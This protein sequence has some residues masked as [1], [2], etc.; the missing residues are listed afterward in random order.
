MLLLN[1]L[2]DYCESHFSRDYIYYNIFFMISSFFFFSTLPYDLFAS[3]PGI[4]LYNV[5]QCSFSVIVQCTSFHFLFAITFQYRP[6]TLKLSFKPG[7][8]IT[9]EILNTLRSNVI[10]WIHRPF[11]GVSCFVLLFLNCFLFWDF[12]STKIVLVNPYI[13]MSK[14]FKFHRFYFVK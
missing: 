11:W 6:I 1:I 4:Y 7:Q 10:K 13:Q 8:A 9:I 2:R 14:D 12:V 5:K 3:K